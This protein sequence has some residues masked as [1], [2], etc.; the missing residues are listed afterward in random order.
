MTAK[1]KKRTICYMCDIYPVEEGERCCFMCNKMIEGRTI[2]N[3]NKI[4]GDNIWF[5][6]KEIEKRLE[7]CDTLNVVMKLR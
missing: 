2:R 1:I 5:R 3:R 7:K 4:K 6:L